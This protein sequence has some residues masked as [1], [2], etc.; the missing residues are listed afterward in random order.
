MIRIIIG[1]SSGRMSKRIIS[2]LSKEKDIR[3]TAA[4]EKKNHEDIGKELRNVRGVEFDNLTCQVTDDLRKVIDDSD[5]IIEFTTPKVTLKHLKEAVKFK[6][7]MIIGTTGLNK[8]E[9]N[10][11][12]KASS[13]IAVFFSPNMSLGVN[14]VFSL[15]EK[16]SSSLP[17]NYHTEIVETHHKFKKDAPSGTAKRMAEIIAKTRRDNP[18]KVIV[19]GRE[20]I[21]GQRP[22]NQICIHAVR[23]GS[24]VGKHEVKFISDEEEILITH[25]A[26]SRDIFAKGAVLA[27][28]FLSKKKKGFYTMADL[29]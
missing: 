25:N 21:S 3:I 14:L 26:F 18:D 24:V 1:G 28:K 17:S 23:A 27:A 6:K 13:K 11:I 29:I 7:A 12:K 4:I 15:L 10:E 9:L 8:R 5:V 2:L 19:F 20:G 16:T 22:D